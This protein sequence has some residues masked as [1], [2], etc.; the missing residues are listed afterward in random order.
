M[1]D[2]NIP[3]KKKSASPEALVR[4]FERMVVEE[5]H[6][7]DTQDVL[8][9]KRRERIAG[10]KVAALWVGLWALL[11]AVGLAVRGAWAPDETRWL[12]TAWEMWARGSFVVPTLNGDA[13]PVPPLLF[14]L[15]NASWRIAGVSELGA[16][17]VPALGLASSLFVVARLAALLW[18]EEREVARY[19]PVLLLGSVGV[20]LIAGIA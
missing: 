20:L 4:K 14:W 3:P 9:A 16:R 1:P 18:P 2:P 10:L 13:E 8:V 19:A 11:T 17:L 7:E 5:I 15:M 12:A 6:V